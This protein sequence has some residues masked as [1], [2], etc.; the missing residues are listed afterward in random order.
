MNLTH[1]A[2]ARTQQRAIPRL[3]LDLLLQFGA[4]EPAPNAAEMV[5]FD[6]TARKRVAS[7][8]G[9]LAN[10]LNEHLDVYAIVGNDERV[11]TTG[12]RLARIQRH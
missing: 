4:R 5:F 9:A 7:Y 3:V 8:A 12:H 1:H 10:R 2:Q 11:I 6:K